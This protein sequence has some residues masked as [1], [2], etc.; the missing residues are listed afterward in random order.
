MANPIENNPTPINARPKRRPP[1]AL[2]DLSLALRE[3]L[4]WPVEDRLL[5]LERNGRA[6]VAGGAV[7]LA[8]GLGVGGYSLLGSGSS[9]PTATSPVAVVNERAP[10]P[11]PVAPAPE[12]KPEPKPE[13]EPTLHGA[14]PVFKP[15]PGEEKVG[16]SKGVE[17][18]AAPATSVANTGDPATDT[19][20]SSPTAPAAAA[21]TS[22]AA[23]TEVPDGPPAGPAAIA[24]AR[25]F[26]DAF[27]V[28]E[29]GGDATTIR[30]AFSATATPELTKAL[31]RRPPHQPAGIEVPKAKVLNIVPAPS[32]G[33]IYPLSVSLLRVGATSELRLEMEQLKNQGWRVTNV[34]G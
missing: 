9:E 4:L 27:V 22:K 2:E 20:T 8:L 14:A 25:K 26:A 24:V 12:A 32:H 5:G 33:T 31:M 7:V 30:K 13:P 11:T 28:Y 18:P 1:E 29:T 6:A 3:H 19:I 16:K 34:L 21:T 23:R 17:S 15:A 10:Q